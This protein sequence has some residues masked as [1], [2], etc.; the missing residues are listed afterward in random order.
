MTTD[1]I[2]AE[3]T[4]SHALEGTDA[5]KRAMRSAQRY[6][7]EATSDATRKA[8]RSDARIIDAWL[9]TNGVEWS[10]PALA[11]LL[12]DMAAGR[13]TSEAQ[14]L[15]DDGDTQALDALKAS[16][17]AY[18][19]APRAVATVE[20][21]LASMRAIERT[22]EELGDAS[23]SAA[24][25]TVMRGIR[26]SNRKPQDR[27]AAFELEDVRQYLRIT[28]D[29][30]NRVE[31][32]NRALIAVGFACA[33]RRSELTAFTLED[34]TPAADGYTI[35]TR[36]S[37]TDQEG[38]GHT[39]AVPYGGPAEALER[40]LAVRGDD[41]GPVFDIHDRTV[42]RAVKSAAKAL[43]YDSAAYSGHSLRAGHATS[44]AALGLEERDIMRTT[45]HR[46]LEVARR[47]IRQGSVW[48]GSTAAAMFS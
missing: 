14:A 23:R 19:T 11:T 33:M 15:E 21:Y 7:D 12:A 8:W 9:T 46:S 4:T 29:S 41:A 1:I 36:R 27:A 31:V 28:E 24:V 10:A 35:N 42:S 2:E 5:L 43:G 47:Y 38:D 16:G 30:P 48:R 13:L 18:A 39:R 6:A 37:K 32:R 25:R 17:E 34:V 26:R 22:R 3:D 40:W 45:G 20:R 44:A